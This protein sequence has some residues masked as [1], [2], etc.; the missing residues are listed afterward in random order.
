[1]DVTSLR[2]GIGLVSQEP[3]LLPGSIAYNVKLGA[4]AEQDVTD[5]DIENACKKCGLHD[6]ITSLPDGYNTDC[7]SNGSAKLSGGQRQ[8]VAL[9]R[10]FIREPEILLLDEPTSALDAH[11][12]RQVQEA[13]QDVAQNLTTLIVAHRLA[14][15]QHVDRIVVFDQGRVVEHGTHAELVEMAGLYASMAKAQGLA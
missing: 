13:I 1:M 7:G 2:N 14:S 5:H 10:A 11:S 15:I 3:D 9:A 12:E 4:T 6:F 8:R